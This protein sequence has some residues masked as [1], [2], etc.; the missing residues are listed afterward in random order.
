MPGLIWSPAALFDVQRAYRFLVTKNANAAKRAMK[1]LRSGVRVIAQ[2]PEIGRPADEMEPEYREWP[3][4]FGGLGYI[5]LYRHDGH[6]AMIVAVRHQ[7]ELG[8]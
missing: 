3:I 2:H 6:T 8:D 7:K 5:V 1:A 4:D